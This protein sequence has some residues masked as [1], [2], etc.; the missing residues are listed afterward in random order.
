[1]AE[2]ACCLATRSRSRRFRCANDLAEGG[3]CLQPD[4]PSDNL[5][6][7]EG[8]DGG[9]FGW[10]DAGRPLAIS[11]RDSFP[12][13]GHESLTFHNLS[14]Q[15]TSIIS[16]AHIYRLSS[17]QRIDLLRRVG[18]SEENLEVESEWLAW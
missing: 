5:S 12:K 3:I 2:T 16:P 10:V 4:W 18:A 17:S 13:V 15:K 9:R 7:V 8:G 11:T 6:C 14:L 1:M